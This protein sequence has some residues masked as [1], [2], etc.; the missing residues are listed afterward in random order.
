MPKVSTQGR[1]PGPQMPQ[2]YISTGPNYRTWGE[3]PGYYYVPQLDQYFL[4]QR[5][6]EGQ[7]QDQGVIPKPP[8]LLEQI[9]PVAAT[10]GAL[11]GG[12]QLAEGLFS[13]T[14]DDPSLLRQGFDAVK[15]SLGFGPEAAAAQASTSGGLLGAGGASVGGSGYSGSG[16]FVGSASELADYNAAADAAQA[17]GA[18][19][20]GLFSVGSTSGN[21]LGGAGVALGG[22]QAFQGIK[23]GNPL[24]AGLGGAGV[25]AGL[26]QLGYAI[27]GIG[28]AAAIGLPVIG[29][30]VGKLGDKDAWKTEGDNL[31]KLQK[32]GIYI[33]EV[34]LSNLPTKGRSK[35][36][37][38]EIARQTGGNVKFAES[39]KEE[40]LEGRDIIGFSTFAEHDPEW[41]KRPL[42]QQISYAQSLLDSGLVR[43]HHGTVDV[44]WKKAPPPPWEQ[45][46]ASQ[47]NQKATLGVQNAPTA[48]E[49]AA[50]KAIAPSTNAASGSSK[51]NSTNRNSTAYRQQ[52]LGV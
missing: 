41:F 40:D 32:K 18:S 5:Q 12:K 34:L 44:D 27:P 2:K 6:L 31:K 4:D 28:W 22:Y 29:A 48:A 33:P 14:K 19:G 15:G 52:Y 24:Q 1:S 42:E 20:G 47:A 11:Y 9:T 25:A 8:G 7:L 49:A 36:E 10:A 37:L 21:I 16:G 51:N 26:S 50:I 45:G 23:E 46:N 38:I 39:R 30:L 13:G 17:P 43:E 35:E 3:Q